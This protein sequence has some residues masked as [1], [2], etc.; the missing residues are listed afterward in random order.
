MLRKA[1]ITSFVICGIGSVWL[2]VYMDAGY[3]SSMPRSPQ[4]ELGRVYRYSVKGTDHFVTR[5]ELERIQFVISKVLPIGFVLG[6]MGLVLSVYWTEKHP[7][8][9]KYPESG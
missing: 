9:K 5:P 4:P 7:T 1:I 2:S 8:K 6:L 3:A